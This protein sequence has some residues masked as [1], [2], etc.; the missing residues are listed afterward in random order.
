MPRRKFHTEEERQEAQ[1]AAKRES[2]RKYY[3]DPENRQK[4]IDA[5]KASYAKVMADPLIR[6]PKILL[7]GVDKGNY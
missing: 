5:S 2:T 7:E 3:E 4:H 1:R 6:E